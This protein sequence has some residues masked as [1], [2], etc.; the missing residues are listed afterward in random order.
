[1]TLATAGPRPGFPWSVVSG[2]WAVVSGQWSVGSG[3]WAVGSGQWSG[4]RLRQGRGRRDLLRW[5]TRGGHGCCRFRLGRGGA[6]DRGRGRWGG[7]DDARQ[8]PRQIADHC[9][10]G[11]VGRRLT[12]GH[13]VGCGGSGPAAARGARERSDRQPEG[14]GTGKPRGRCAGMHEGLNFML[15]VRSRFT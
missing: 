1:M 5:G 6:E 7:H 8:R 2:Q 11:W 12:D 13:E 14:H 4:S 15:G 10:Q 3:Q 9:V